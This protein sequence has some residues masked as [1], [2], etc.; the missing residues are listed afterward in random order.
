MEVSWGE[1]SLANSELLKEMMDRSFG[2]ERPSLPQALSRATARMSSLTTMAVGASSKG[3]ALEGRCHPRRRGI[4]FY[5]VGGIRGDPVAEQRRLIACLPVGGKK[6]GAVGAKVS[7]FPVS[8]G[9]EIFRGLLSRQQIVVVNVD[10]LIG[11]PVGLA[12][13]DVKKPFF[14][15]VVDDLIVLPGVEDDKAVNLVFPH[16]KLDGRKDFFVVPAGEDRARV[17]PVVAELADTADGFQ[18]ERIFVGFPG[19]GRQNDADR[20]AA[21]EGGRASCST[22]V[23]AQLG[24]GA[25]NLFFCFPA[26][27]GIV[28]A[29]PGNGG[30][31]HPGQCSHI[32]YS[33]SHR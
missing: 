14:V 20:A 21:L 27:G 11:E 23:I 17:L 25:A 12:D 30:R 10:R 9:I 28:L 8:E 1:V 2:M 6:Q 4:F 33:N 3:E 5:A 15:K 19:R 13:Q 7:D 32:F 31:G 16:H 26:D 29:R 22:G 24:H 18:I